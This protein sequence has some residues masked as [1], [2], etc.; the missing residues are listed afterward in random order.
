MVCGCTATPV[1]VSTCGALV[2]STAELCTLRPNASL[3]ATSATAIPSGGTCERSICSAKVR[4]PGEVERGCA[5][6]D[7][8]ATAD[9][10]ALSMDP[11]ADR[12]CCAEMTVAC[13]SPDATAPL[14]GTVMTSAPPARSACSEIPSPVTAG[15]ESRGSNRCVSG[16]PVAPLAS[17]GVAVTDRT[18]S[19][20]HAALRLSSAWN[21]AA[22]AASRDTT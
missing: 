5:L 12:S 14:Y 15:V 7:E 21:G 22:P 3:S 1:S 4:A 6:A 9:D 16:V 2:N 8:T 19:A 11:P 13:T 18:P 10:C 17:T 20:G